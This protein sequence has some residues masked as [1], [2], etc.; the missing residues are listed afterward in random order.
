MTSERQTP[1]V[2]YWQDFLPPAAECVFPR[3]IRSGRENLPSPDLILETHSCNPLH[4]RDAC[5]QCHPACY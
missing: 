4:P 1:S 5:P 3:A 2:F